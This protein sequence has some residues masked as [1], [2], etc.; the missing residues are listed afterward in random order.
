MVPQHLEGIRHQKNHRDSLK[1]LP[2]L[3]LKARCTSVSPIA[4]RSYPTL[5]SVIARAQCWHLP[6]L[7]GSYPT[8]APSVAHRLDPNLASLIACAQCWHFLSSL[9]GSYPTPASSTAHC[10]YPVLASP[11]PYQFIPSDGIS[12][13]SS[14]CT[15][16]WHL[17]SLVGSYP[18][19][20]SPIA[21]T[22]PQPHAWTPALSLHIWVALCSSFLQPVIFLQPPVKAS[23]RLSPSPH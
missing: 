4:R 3:G 10:S 21:R 18:T 16:R 6:S 19:L 5:A 8:L 23:V 9:I 12:H 11:I 17:P 7:I 13:H 14:V 22:Q 1:S 20:T 2:G 15:Q